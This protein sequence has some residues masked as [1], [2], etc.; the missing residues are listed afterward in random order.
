MAGTG[1]RSQAGFRA[2]RLPQRTTH[3]RGRRET[4]GPRGRGEKNGPIRHECPPLARRSSD[5]ARESMTPPHRSRRAPAERG[6]ASQPANRS[7][8]PFPALEGGAADNPA[9]TRTPDT[10]GTEP[11]G[12]GCHGRPG[13]PQ[14]RA[15]GGRA[16]LAAFPAAPRWVRDPDPGR[17]RGESGRSDARES[18]RLTGPSRRLEQEQGRLAG[19]PV[20]QRPARI[21]RPNLSSDRS[22]EDSVSAI[23]RWPKMPTRS[24][25]YTSPGGRRPSHRPRRRPRRPTTR[26]SVPKNATITARRGA[27]R[28]LWSTPGHT[29]EQPRAGDALPATRATRRGR[30]ASP[31][32]DPEAFSAGPSYDRD[33]RG[34]EGR[35]GVTSRGRT[36]AQGAL[37]D[38]ARGLARKDHGRGTAPRHPGDGGRTVPGS[39]RGL[40][41][42]FGRRLRRPGCARARQGRP[43]PPAPR[44]A[45]P[46]G[47]RLG[48]RELRRAGR[49]ARAA[50]TPGSGSEA[51]RQPLPHINLHA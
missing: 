46:R 49:P 47:S 4:R 29:R 13:C 17:H 43:Q 26:T 8:R 24:E 35:P 33:T 3:R 40:G 6:S 20:S 12:W 51:Q 1:Q 14:R 34:T 39:P 50:P 5:P 15:H 18:S 41:N 21:Q 16:A 11:T 23:T 32:R 42:K 27:P 2:P 31:E 44:A 36:R 28:A 22:P 10:R 45:G 38:S 7:A 9:E 30:P 25:R 19:S 48:P 37:S